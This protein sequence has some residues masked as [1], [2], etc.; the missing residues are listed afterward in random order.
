MVKLS[1]VI[2]GKN[3]VTHV[4]FLLL[5][6][7]LRCHNG[8]G[9]GILTTHNADDERKILGMSFVLCSTHCT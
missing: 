4:Q 1:M 7:I 8:P 3:G 2:H 6:L 9:F 5:F